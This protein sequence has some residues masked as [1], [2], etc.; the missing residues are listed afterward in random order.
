[1]RPLPDAT[2]FS[3]LRVQFKRRIA[4]LRVDRN[5]SSFLKHGIL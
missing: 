2:M 1:M 5:S 4:S 3:C